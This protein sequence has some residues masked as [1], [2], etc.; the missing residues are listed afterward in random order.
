MADQPPPEDEDTGQESD[1]GIIGEIP[2][3]EADEEEAGA[4]DRPRP[5]GRR[6]R[7]RTIGCV[8]ALLGALLGAGVALVIGRGGGNEGEPARGPDMAA[9]VDSYLTRLTFSATP[10]RPEQTPEILPAEADVIYCFYEL[11][12]VS[13]DA[14]LSARWSYDGRD[15]GELPLRDHQPDRDAEHASGRFSIVPAE[16]DEGAD[17]EGDA[18]GGAGFPRGVYEVEMTSPSQPDVIAQ[19]SFVALPRAAKILQ[20]GGEPEGPPLV[21]SLNTAMGVGEDGKPVGATTTFEADSGRI[22][23]AFEYA[24]VPPGAVLTVRWHFADTEL[25]RA[26]A[27]LPVSAAEGRGQAWLEVGEGEELPAGEY[28]VS[29]HLGDEDEELATSGFTVEGPMTAADPAAPPSVGSPPE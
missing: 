2:P 23:A 22:Y 8:L 11:S 17:V 19:A 25:E 16:S 13:P 27:E 12:R 9:P 26:R 28:R 15:L 3:V 29:V 10:E 14:P 4:R 20:G 7:S 18:E 1:Q 6:R 5:P 24:G 21:R